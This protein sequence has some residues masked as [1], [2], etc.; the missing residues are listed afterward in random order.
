MVPGEPQPRL[1][2]VKSQSGLRRDKELI[3]AAVRMLTAAGRADVQSNVVTL[4]LVTFCECSTQGCRD[5]TDPGK[6][7][8]ALGETTRTEPTGSEEVVNNFI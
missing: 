4:A 7:T 3:F 5:A 1:Q 6:V 8:P 2:A